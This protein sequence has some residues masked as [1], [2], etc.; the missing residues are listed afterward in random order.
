VFVFDNDFAALLAD[1]TQPDAQ[2][3]DLFQS[4]AERGRS[5]VLCYSPQHNLSLGG[6]SAGALLGVI[7][8]W[9][10]EYEMLIADYPWVQIFENRGAAMGASNPHPHGQIWAQDHVPSLAAREQAAQKEYFARNHSAMLL[11]YA[12]AEI[13]RA[14]RVVVLNDDW[15]VVVPYWAAWPFET[16]LLPRF[17]IAHIGQLINSQK[18]SLGNILQ[19]LQRG[20]D[21][22]FDCE[23]PYSFG[24]HNAPAEW[25]ASGGEGTWQLHAHFYPPLLR[26][27]S[28]KKFMVGYEMLAEPQRDLTPELAA[29]NLRPVVPAKV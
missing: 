14:E 4:H 24:W 17:S 21:A 2:A 26:S 18:V 15:V 13:E 9:I 8:T 5:R 29:A 22:L 7:N 25:L 28:V 1:S 3:S 23:F 12:Q 20:Y 16:L 6:L 19:R 11:D 10:S 27:A